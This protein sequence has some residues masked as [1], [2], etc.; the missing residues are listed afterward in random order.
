MMQDA[1]I[2]TELTDVFREV[3]DDASIEIRDAM[4]AKDVE[5]WDSLNHI[6]LI[7]AVEQKFGIRFT[8]KEVSNLANVGE[9]IALIASKL[10]KAAGRS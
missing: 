2:R 8:T 1:E 10:S 3:F 6:N 5:E 9:F 7:V 4:T